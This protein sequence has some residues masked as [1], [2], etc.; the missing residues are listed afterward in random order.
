MV[1]KHR[2][3]VYGKIK[4]KV[5]KFINQK[6]NRPLQS[7]EWGFGTKVKHCET[8]MESCVHAKNP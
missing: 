8:I 6:L 5:K 1:L 3:S 4:K 7:L 2:M